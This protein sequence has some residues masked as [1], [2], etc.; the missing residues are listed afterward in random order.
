MYANAQLFQSTS[1]E[2]IFSMDLTDSAVGVQKH[3]H[4]FEHLGLGNQLLLL[5]QMVVCCCAGLSYEAAMDYSAM[6]NYSP[7]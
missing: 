6:I 2:G 3:A 5:S 1:E 4:M 7:R